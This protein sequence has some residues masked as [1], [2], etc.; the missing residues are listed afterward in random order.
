LSPLVQVMEQPSFVF[1]HLHLANA[2]LHWQ[3]HTPFLQQLHEQHPSHSIRQSFCS[4]PQATS[5]SHLHLILQPSL[6]F[7]NWI[8]HR[9]TT[10]QLG[11]TASATG[12][13]AGPFADRTGERRRLCVCSDNNSGDAFAAHGCAL[14]RLHWQDPAMASTSDFGAFDSREP[15]PTLSASMAQVPVNFADKAPGA[16]EIYAA[17]WTMAHRDHELDKL[18]NAEFYGK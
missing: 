15:L 18:F 6:V 14:P 11:T 4:A 2:K 17:A 8:L 7:S 1:S 9:G 12:P 13:D 10:F 16:F 5:S 3:Q